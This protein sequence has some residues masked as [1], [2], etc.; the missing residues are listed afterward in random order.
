MAGA[1]KGG[2]IGVGMASLL[3]MPTQNIVVFISF[4][5][6][7]FW[8]VRLTEDVQPSPV[9]FSGAIKSGAISPPSL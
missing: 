2:V 5:A 8:W 6:F 1:A 3:G 7:A 9:S 4:V